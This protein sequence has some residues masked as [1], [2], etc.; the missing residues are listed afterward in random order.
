MPVTRVDRSNGPYSGR[1]YVGW[2]DNRNGEDDNDV[3]LVYSDEQGRNWTEPVRVND[4]LTQ[5]RS[6]SFRG[7]IS[8][9]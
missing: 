1:V 5:V 9:T 4:D 8:T 6:S 3:W 2:T 7:W